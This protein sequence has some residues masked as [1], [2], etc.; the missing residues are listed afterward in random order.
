MKKFIRIIPLLFTFPLLLTSC[1]FTLS[2]PSDYKGL[3]WLNDKPKD[4]DLSS[5]KRELVGDDLGVGIFGPSVFVYYEAK[6][7]SDENAPLLY[8]AVEHGPD[9]IVN[10]IIIQ[11]DD[12]SVY[13]FNINSNLEDFKNYFLDLGFESI[14]YDNTDVE[15]EVI[16]KKN[17]YKIEYYLNESISLYLYLEKDPNI[18]Y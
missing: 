8:V 13:G 4:Y 5:Y 6:Y 15:K 9:L 17:D 2:K 12:Y 14:V 10:H 18:I 1:S 7:E 11:D 3:M 16:L